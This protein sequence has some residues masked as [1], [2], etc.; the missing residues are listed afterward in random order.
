LGR[1]YWD[2]LHVVNFRDVG[3]WV[4]ESAKR[5]F[6]PITRLYRGGTI[7]YMKSLDVIC[8]PRTIFNLTNGPDPGFPGV[9][10][11]DFPGNHEKYDTSDSEVRRWL[12]GIMETVEKGVEYRFPWMRSWKNTC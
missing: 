2:P 6:L 1:D 9:A 12:S 3:S 4:N 11:Y 10:T 7:K 8:N 5:S